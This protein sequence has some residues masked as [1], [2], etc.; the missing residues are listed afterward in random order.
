MELVSRKDLIKNYDQIPGTYSQG[1]RAVLARY[2]RMYPLHAWMM[3]TTV[4]R[5]RA[6]DRKHHSMIRRIGFKANIT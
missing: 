5:D 1:C 2:T 4:I 3:D 6:N